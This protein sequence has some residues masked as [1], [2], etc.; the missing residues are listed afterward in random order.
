MAAAIEPISPDRPQTRVIARAATIIKN[1]GV[2]VFPT[3]GLYG[4]AADALNPAAVDRVF[5]IKKRP[6][7][8]PV[9]VLIGSSSQLGRLVRSV[10]AVSVKI[11]ERFWPGRITLVFEAAADLPANLTAGTGKIGI[12]LPGYPPAAALASAVG[13][14]I[15]A[16]SANV[17]GRPGCHDSSALDPEILEAADLVLDAGALAGGPGSTVVDVTCTPPMVLR[18]GAV[19]AASLAAGIGPPDFPPSPID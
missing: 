7:A 16:T 18:E 6:P 2:V 17:S 10:P 11:M 14:P 3:R 12:R 8:K 13:S 19:S 5:C 4:V 1:G 15:T 9:S